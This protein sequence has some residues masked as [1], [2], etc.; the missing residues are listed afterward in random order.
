MGVKYEKSR[1]EVEHLVLTWNRDTALVKKGA[2]AVMFSQGNGELIMQNHPQV[3]L[4]RFSPDEIQAVAAFFAKA[5][6]KDDGSP[7]AVVEGDLAFY[8]DITREQTVVAGEFGG[9]L[10][11][12]LLNSA[13]R[14]GGVMLSMEEVEQLHA[15]LGKVLGK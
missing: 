9:R 5:C 7:K 11:L 3:G 12:R 1:Y 13:H 10:R 2:E 8:D 6:T 4:V 14:I 15:Y